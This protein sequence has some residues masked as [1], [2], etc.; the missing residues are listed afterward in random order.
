MQTVIQRQRVK[1]KE[2]QAQI[3]LH[4]YMGALMSTL[5]T[6]NMKQY[7]N[8]A[9]NFPNQMSQTKSDISSPG[10]TLGQRQTYYQRLDVLATIKPAN[11]IRF[12]DKDVDNE[13]Q[14]NMQS[15]GGGGLDIPSWVRANYIDRKANQ[16]LTSTAAQRTPKDAHL[17]D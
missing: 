2:L 12:I 13:V 15:R 1:E 9:D 7:M 8:I 17:A 6:G 16:I 14:L 3:G 5:T 11:K 10:Q 4:P